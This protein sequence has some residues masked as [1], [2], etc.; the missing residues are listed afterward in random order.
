MS[1]SPGP[2]TDAR[3][4]RAPVDE[5]RAAMGL[6][7]AGLDRRMARR[8]VGATVLALASG[9]LVG[10]AP[11]ALKELIDAAS[12]GAAGPGGSMALAGLGLAYLLSLA[13]AR[14]IAEFRPFLIGAVEQQLYARLRLRYFG[15]VLDLP[16]SFHLSRQTG[17]LG[18]HL[19]Q[20]VTGYQVILSCLLNGLVPVLVEAVTVAVV[21]ISLGQPALALNFS[22]TAVALWLVLGRHMTPLRS[23]ARSVTD[24]TAEAHGLLADS[25]VN[26]E[27]IKCFGAE[28]PALDRFRGLCALLERR[29]QDLQSRRLKMGAAA[30]AIFTLSVASSLGLAIHGVSRGTLSVGGFVLAMLYMV[31]IIRPLELLSSAARDMSQGLAFVRP[32]LVTLGVP[33]PHAAHA[34]HAAHAVHTAHVN[35]ER[36]GLERS[37]PDAERGESKGCKS[38]APA[39][40]GAGVAVSFRG[41]R[42]SFDGGTPVLHD[43][44]LDIPAGRSLAIVGASGGGKSSLVR[45]LLRLCEPDGGRIALDGVGIDALPVTELRSMIAVVLQDLAL[46]NSTIGANIALGMEDATPASIAEAAR[47][48]GLHDFVATLPA[49]YDTPIGERGL[50]LSGGERQRIAIARAIL[51]NPR[52]YVFDEATSM[53]DPLTERAIMRRIKALSNGRTVLIIAHRLAAIRQADEIAVLAGGRIVERG[54]HAGLLAHGGVYAGLWREQQSGLTA[55][56]K[57]EQLSRFS[58]DATPGGRRQH[59]MP[60]DRAHDS[61]RPS[62]SPPP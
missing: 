58:N 6:L 18:H 59:A 55:Q 4:I 54:V 8:L 36:L 20:A 30:T 5:F 53:L 33:A 56:A 31:Q 42:L 50:K 49:G 34:A 39:R 21:L 47:L 15:H 11:V 13:T 46:L 14:L 48:A 28:R 57:D 61:I 40:P 7:F 38:G 41:V 2:S 51:R 45:L 62:H 26:Y 10:L 22:V 9:A 37:N 25:L 35:Q 16:L 60:V 24:A 29:W 43:L 44:D 27:P 3:A 52:L 32:L 19:Q 1:R 23:C 17:V 12:R